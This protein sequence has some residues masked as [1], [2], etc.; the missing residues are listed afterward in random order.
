LKI[1]QSTAGRSLRGV[2]I[3]ITVLSIV[4]FATIA[5]SAYEDS[6]GI[7]GIF[8]AG[9]Q[10]PAI[11]ARAVY[12]G[13]TAVVSVNIT[14]HNNGLYPLDISI[15]CVQTP[16]GLNAT[17]NQPGTTIAMSQTETLHFTM[18]VTGVSPQTGA[19]GRPIDADVNV[20][21]D[22]FVSLEVTANLGGLVG[23]AP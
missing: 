5:Y 4:I 22:P 1:E 10:T 18:M 23:V 15:S 14:L 7:L 8:G 16:G 9:S 19:G 2:S 6:V 12:Q 13:S 17:C 3:A 20:T 11:T 21:L